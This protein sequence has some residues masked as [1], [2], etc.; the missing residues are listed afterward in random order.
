M[1]ALLKARAMFPLRQALTFDFFGVPD[2][3]AFIF[4]VHIP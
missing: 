2:K 3:Y 4:G 1:L